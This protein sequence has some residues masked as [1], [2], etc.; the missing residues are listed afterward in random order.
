MKRT[1]I[2]LI[3]LILL[4]SQTMAGSRKPGWVKQ[5]PNN[6]DYY[7]GIAFCQK[8]ASS[9]IDYMQDTRTRALRELSSEIE[10]T[11]SS[12][13][14][15]HQLE[16]NNDFY[17]SYE[18][19]INASVMQTLEGYELETWEDKKEYWVIA[20]LSKAKHKLQK[21]IKLDRAKMTASVH[22]EEA[23]KHLD[24][25]HPY[26]A[27]EAYFKAALSI[28]DHLEADLTHRSIHGTQNIGT[29]IQN[30]IT[31]TLQSL[32]IEPGQDTYQIGRTGIANLKPTAQVNHNTSDGKLP[33]EGVPVTFKF[34]AGSGNL[35]ER[36][37]SNSDGGVSTSISNIKTGLKNQQ[38]LIELD[39]TPMAEMF[40]QNEALFKL[41]LGKT[42]LPHTVITIELEKIL[43]S[44]SIQEIVVDNQKVCESLQ[45]DIKALLSQNYFIFTQNE[46]LSKYAISINPTVTKGETKTGNGYTVYVVYGGLN[47]TIEDI[48]TGHEV[49]THNISG[50]R[51]FQPG[52]YG[53]AIAAACR[54]ILSRFQEEVVPA[55]DQ[56]EL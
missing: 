15:L 13:S 53:H 23:Q 9:A 22:M 28:K 33:S 10:V 18:S 29:A 11:I 19:K 55:L 51:G 38:V 44:F 5:R 37:V 31:T 41:F 40:E 2:L 12:N 56:L 26:A 21:E 1:Y 17:Q 32:T 8:K 4:V 34:I 54:T 3:S 16:N 45:R 24:N 49:F 35:Q 42:P 47:I 6:P 52:S 14:I 46:Q 25:R 27:L 43:A 36:A 30:G 7:I 48:S 20:R 39:T 50:V